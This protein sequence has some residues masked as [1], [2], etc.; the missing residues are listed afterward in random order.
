V[1]TSFLGRG[2]TRHRIRSQ[3]SVH[4][5]SHSITFQA[6]Y[7]FRHSPRHPLLHPYNSSWW[8]N[9]SSWVLPLHKTEIPLHSLVRYTFQ[10]KQSPPETHLHNNTHCGG[11]CVDSQFPIPRMILPV[12]SLMVPNKPGLCPDGWPGGRPRLY[13]L[14]LRVIPRR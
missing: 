10:D 14:K 6:Y 3:S 4:T 12:A 5:V 7:S 9:N 1:F 11:R 8:Y 2:L 13:P